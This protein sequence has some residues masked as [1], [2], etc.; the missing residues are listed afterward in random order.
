MLGVAMGRS[1]LSQQDEKS[2]SGGVCGVLVGLL[3][4]HF[5]LL[6]WLLIPFSWL[7]ERWDGL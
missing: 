1:I 6:V 7:E 3:V 5:G 4:D 2:A